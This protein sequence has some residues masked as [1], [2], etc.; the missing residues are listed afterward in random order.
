MIGPSCRQ[1]PT[2]RKNGEMRDTA[3]RFWLGEM[4]NTAFRSGAGIVA[5]I[6][7]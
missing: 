3:F 5:S 6:I 4:Q 1:A 7:E 2:A